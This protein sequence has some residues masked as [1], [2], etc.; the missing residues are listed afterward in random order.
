MRRYPKR[1]VRSKYLTWNRG[2]CQEKNGFIIVR[3]KNPK[4][5]AVKGG[6]FFLMQEEKNSENIKEIYI[7]CAGADG[8]KPDTYYGIRRQQICEEKS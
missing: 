1:V 8:I 7:G 2:E 6:A 5:K 3:G 4:A